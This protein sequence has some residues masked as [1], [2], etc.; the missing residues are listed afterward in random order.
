MA[1]RAGGTEAVGTSPL[2]GCRVVDFSVFVAAPL[3]SLVLAEQGADVIK[4]EPLGGDPLRSRGTMSQGVGAWFVGT[5]RLK[6]SVAVNLKDPRGLD[7]VRRV[8][9]RSDVLL[10]QFRDGVADRL[11]IGEADVRRTNPRLIYASLTGFGRDGP[12]A[13]RRAYDNIIQAYVGLNHI[14]GVGASGP[15]PIRT[16]LADKV[17][18]LILAQAITAALYER[19]KSGVGQRIDLSMLHSMLWWMWADG[20]TDHTF[21]G[22]DVVKGASVSEIQT[23][24]PTTDGFLTITIASPDEWEALATAAERPDWLTHPELGR[25][26]WRVRNRPAT[27]AVVAEELTTRSTE[28]WL[29]R[30]AEVDAAAGPV[31]SLADVVVDD[32][33]VANH[34]L[35]EL[36][37][38]KAGAHIQPTHPVTFSRT[39]ARV[40]PAPGLGANTRQ[41]L[42]EL[43]IAEDE[44]VA[45]RD[46]GV[47]AW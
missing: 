11:G 14:Q 42:T 25:H 5:N 10:H 9:D 12:F 17:P 45:L 47:V 26:E 41:V 1:P 44:Q 3:A 39:P 16:I 24:F 4:I 43:G 20:F 31:N 21:R 38:E 19:E 46:D 30:F 29:R 33:V 32:Q 40:G 35:V 36:T 18:P 27:L 28:E 34:M 37:D 22:D 23:I 13:G 8:I 7:V 15:Q 6:R 2:D